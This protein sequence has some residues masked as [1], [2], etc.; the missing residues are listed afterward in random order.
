MPEE[1]EPKARILLIEDSEGTSDLIT[2]SLGQHGY[3]VD[4]SYDG[5]SGLEAALTGGYDMLILD[6]ALPGMFG[7]EV[8]RNIREAEGEDQMPVIVVTAHHDTMLSEDSRDVAKTVERVMSKPFD[9][10]DLS[11]TV[12]RV[13]GHDE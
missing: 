11:R 9:L 6:I 4:T 1:T 13:L 10:A 3:Q 2:R 5:P 12:V 7:W 8:L